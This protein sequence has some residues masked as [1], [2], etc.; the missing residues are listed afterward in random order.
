[1]PIAAIAATNR[2]V[3]GLFPKKPLK[4]IVG[5]VSLAPAV[6]QGVAGITLERPAVQVP[7]DPTDNEWGERY[8]QQLFSLLGYRIWPNP[9]NSYFE[10]S[11]WGLPSGPIHPDADPDGDK[12]R[13]PRAAAADD[14]WHFS[15]VVPYA[16]VI[17]KGK[18]GFSP[19]GG[20]GGILQLDFAWLDIFGN[21]ILSEFDNLQP[22]VGTPLNKLPQI[23]GYA[24]R[25]LGVGQW[26]SVGHNYQVAKNTGSQP[27][28]Q[29]NL[30]FD[31]SAYKEA[32]AALRGSNET[33]AQ[34]GKQKLEQAIAVYTLIDQQLQD[35][36]GV[37][38]EV[39]T[40]M[41]PTANWLIPD[42]TVN[43]S[44]SSARNGP[45]PS[46]SISRA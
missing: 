30:G 37:T 1:M 20:V 8:M 16:S 40:S 41:T 14:I 43:G 31:A 11:N 33:T 5:P 45:I 26:P 12:I 17:G 7:G 15:C 28:L 22:P 19:Y 38:I 42:K 25:L 29:I 27:S 21:R 44:R 23:P 3:V 9:E 2:N 34:S 18:S 39:S 24:D 4:A 6:K 32:A 10:E 46:S 35:P 13:A 36:A